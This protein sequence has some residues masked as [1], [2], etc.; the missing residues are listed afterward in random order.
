MQ[1]NH[2]LSFQLFMHQLKQ[3]E[4]PLLDRLM[5]AWGYPYVLDE[6]AFHFTLTNTL[7]GLGEEQQRAWLESA[8]S[9][10][11]NLGVCR[12]DRIALFVEPQA[13]D[14]FELISAVELT[15]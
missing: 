10:F 8:Q 3:D 13:G 9:H 11:A 15:G 14:D 2:K 5:V 7:K 6:F 12:F 4:H 1:M